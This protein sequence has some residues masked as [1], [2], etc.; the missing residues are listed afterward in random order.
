MKKSLLAVASAIT[1]LTSGSISAQT[2]SPGPYYASPS[3]DQQLLAAQRFIV[4]Q[5]WNNL[6][7]LDRETGLVWER[8]PSTTPIPAI[9]PPNEFSQNYAAGRCITLTL[10]G[11]AGWRVPTIQELESLVD[12]TQ[13]PMLP[14]GH[15]FTG[16]GGAYWTSTQF[17]GAFASGDI[18]TVDFGN[19]GGFGL[20]LSVTPPNFTNIKVWCV[21][22]GSG[23]PIQ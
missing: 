4:L 23:Q 10:G 18:Y 13:N 7:V 14:F 20:G 19:A 11:R 3:W 12:T 5:N 15:P 22:S 17:S 1:I 2:I 21:R 8:T 9:L 16:I 6:A